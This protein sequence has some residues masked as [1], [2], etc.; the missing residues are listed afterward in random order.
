M[1]AA[2]AVNK[3]SWTMAAD[4]RVTEGIELRLPALLASG[5]A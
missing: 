1:A 4:K 3:G 5:R 2:T